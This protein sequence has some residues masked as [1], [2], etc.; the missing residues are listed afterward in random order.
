MDD[1]FSGPGDRQDVAHQVLA[2]LAD[3]Q[4]AA[5]QAIDEI[6]LLN[7]VDAQISGEP[8][9]IDA[10]TDIAVAVFKQVDIFLHSLLSNAPRNLLVDRDRGDRDRGSHG[11]ILVPGL[12]RSLDAVPPE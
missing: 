12:D 7:R 5:P 6:D 3:R 1:R 4:R 8:E 10:A 9:L 2:A 11:V